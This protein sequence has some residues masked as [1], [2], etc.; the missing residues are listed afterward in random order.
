MLRSFILTLNYNFRGHVRYSYST[1]SRIYML[2]TSVVP[3]DLSLLPETLA[4]AVVE[5]G[6]IHII[7]LEGSRDQVGAKL[8]LQIL[9]KEHGIE[10][11]LPWNFLPV[12]IA[13]IANKK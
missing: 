1:I 4:D 6:E 11:D 3:G 7:Q 12:R 10:L 2:S 9:A 8:M 5:G 13:L